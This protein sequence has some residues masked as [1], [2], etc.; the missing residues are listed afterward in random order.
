M[1]AGNEDLWFSKAASVGK[2]RWSNLHTSRQARVHC[3]L[4]AGLG[5]FDGGPRSQRNWL[6]VASSLEL[7]PELAA[8][9]TGEVVFGR[10]SMLRGHGGGGDGLLVQLYLPGCFWLSDAGW[11]SV[12]SMATR[13]RARQGLLG[14]N[15][16]WQ[17]LQT[18][19]SAR[20]FCCKFSAF[21]ATFA[22]SSASSFCL[23]FSA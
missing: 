4:L 2:G 5:I 17:P 7:A 14:G 18:S 21:P 11:I 22:S 8:L 23:A 1:S 16:N 10:G 6:F 19:S 9:V 3:R 20:A 15:E 12:A 13:P